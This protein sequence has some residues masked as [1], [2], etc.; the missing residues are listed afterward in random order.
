MIRQNRN[1][2]IIALIAVVNALGYGIIIPILY[3][4]SV[5]FGLSDFQNGLLFSTFSVCQ[6]LSTPIIGRL[7]DKYGRKPLLIVSISGTAVSFFMMAFAPSAIFLFLA[8][9]LDGITAGNIPVASA[10]IS[11]T[12]TQEQRAKGFGIIGASFGFGFIFGPAVSA[13]TVTRSVSLPF[14]IAGII[15]LIAVVITFIFLPETNK[16]L[17]EVKHSPLFNF[18]ILYHAFFDKNVGPTMLITLFNAI[19]FSLLIFAYQ[20]FSLKILHLSANQISLLFT[21]FGVVGFV[22]QIFLV[23]RLVKLV[24]LKKLFTAS[25]LLIA[26]VFFVFFFIRSAWPFVAASVF[27]G[28]S[29]SVI[30]T[31]IPTILSQETDAKSQGSIMG[32]NAS[33][34]SIGQIVGPIVGGIIAAFG[35]SY[36]FLTAGAFSL[37]AYYLSFFVLKRGVKKESAF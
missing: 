17:G 3:S 35:L 7:S 1:L 29:N 34:M 31:L 9:A 2:L 19:S 26:V 8:R 23:H 20:P 16:H 25:T 37:V 21:L 24:G 22:T 11:D 30:Q 10:V 36:P 14:I 18:K 33:Y 32:L 15:S 5:R 12:T 13:L 27:L 4:Y 6:F 28:L